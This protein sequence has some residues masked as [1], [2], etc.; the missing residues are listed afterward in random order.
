[1]QKQTV[2]MMWILTLGLIPLSL[3]QAQGLTLGEALDAPE[4]TWTT[5]GYNEWVPQTNTTH[6]GIDAVE[7]DYSNFT[8]GWGGDRNDR[9]RADCG[10]LLVEQ[11]VQCFV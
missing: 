2:R 10:D 11:Y 7:I 8:W 1:M 3:A 9:D 6:D 4:L 5:H